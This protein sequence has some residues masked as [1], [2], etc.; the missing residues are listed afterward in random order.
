MSFLAV[1]IQSLKRL[2]AE[3]NLTIHNIIFA[4][5]N[6]ASIITTALGILFREM[7]VVCALTGSPLLLVIVVYCI[8]N[9]LFFIFSDLPHGPAHHVSSCIGCDGEA[10]SLAWEERE[11]RTRKEVRGGGDV[12]RRRR[13]W[14]RK[15]RRRRRRRR[16]YLSAAQSEHTSPE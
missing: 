12:R 5:V 10:V 13:R 9:I 16:T 11:E 14:R 2:A 8:N 1:L 15:R 7:G 4:S 6:Y 3:I